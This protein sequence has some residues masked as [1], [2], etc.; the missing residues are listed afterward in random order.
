[1][2]KDDI[3]MLTSG[4]SCLPVAMLENA[5]QPSMTEKSRLFS[6]EEELKRRGSVFS[7]Q[8]FY[9]DPEVSS[10]LQNKVQLHSYYISSAFSD[11]FFKLF[12]FLTLKSM[13]D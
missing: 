3:N 7:G 2:P 13:F 10:E 12:S 4:N 1:M 8:S 6:S 5:K 9:V 11:I